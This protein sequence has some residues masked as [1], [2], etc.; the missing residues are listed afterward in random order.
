MGPLNI[1]QGFAQL[2]VVWKRILKRT[3]HFDLY[4]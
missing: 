4:V 3:S 1:F 2:F